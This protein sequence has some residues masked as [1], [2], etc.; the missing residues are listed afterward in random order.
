VYDATEN[1]IIPAL[2]NMCYIDRNYEIL[3]WARDNVPR[4][5]ILNTKLQLNLHGEQGECDYFEGSIIDFLAQNLPGSGDHQE[6]ISLFEFT[7][8]YMDP[9][10]LLVSF[11]HSHKHGDC[12][13][14][15]L[16]EKIMELG[17]NSNVLGYQITPLQI[18]AATFDFAAVKVLLAA[19]AD[20]NSIGNRTGINWKS[21]TILGRFNCLFGYSPLHI[22]RHFDCMYK[23]RFAIDTRIICE[24]RQKTR[25]QMEG[26]LVEF[27]AKEV[28]LSEV[29][30]SQGK[31][32]DQNEVGGGLPNEVQSSLPTNVFRGK[33]DG[34]YLKL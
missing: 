5:E 26:I 33:W 9:S 24:R 17:A 4:N 19:G 8:K 31:S 10:V 7:T 18:A 25:V 15:C 2:V 22:C 3:K 34:Y 6:L 11:I 21:K 30:E 29:K 13:E 20:P 28:S 16:I 32:G 1:S 23:G 14:Q 27:G 12:E